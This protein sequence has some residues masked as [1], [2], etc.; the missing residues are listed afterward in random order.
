MGV[1]IGITGSI[2]F[3]PLLLILPTM[4]TLIAFI[5]YIAIKGMFM[6]YMGLIAEGLTFKEKVSRMEACYTYNKQD[7]IKKSLTKK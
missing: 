6:K 4:S 2:A 1:F 5:Y 7:L 3:S